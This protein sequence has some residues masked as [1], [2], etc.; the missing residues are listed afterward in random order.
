MSIA[1]SYKERS[2]AN[3]RRIEQYAK[4][5]KSLFSKGTSR[6]VDLAA[7]VDYNKK[8]GQFYFADYPELKKAVDSVVDEIAKGMWNTIYTGR[9]TEW[10]RGTTDADWILGQMMDKSGI[11]SKS[12]LPDSIGKLLNNHDAALKAFQSRQIGG[13]NLSSRVWNLANQSKIEAE[14]A[15]SI[16]NGT[17]AQD[18]A[19]SM[20]QYLKEPTKLFRRVRD[21][22]GVLRLSRAAK[23]FTP[24]NGAYRSSY[25]NALRLARNEINMAYRHAEQESYKDK[26][27]VVGIEIKRSN[28]PYDC[29]IC[30]SLAGKY[31][32]D[33]I[34]SGWH[35]NCRCYM[36]PITVSRQEFI[37]MITDEDIDPSQS[38]NAVNDVPDN[39]KDWISQNAE[40]MSLAEQRGTEP[41]FIK[42]NPEYVQSI[43][44]KGSI[45]ETDNIAKIS[46]IARKQGT[47]SAE[48]ISRVLEVSPKTLTQELY[49]V[50]DG[51]YDKGR[52]QLHQEIIRK[53]L[54]DNSSKSDTVFMLGGAPAN[55]KSTLVDSGMLKFPKGSLVID[56]D[57]VKAMIP[58]Y[59]S[60]LASGDKNLVAAAA[61]FVHEESSMLGKSIQEKAFKKGM[62]VVI[63]GVNDGKFEKVQKNVA[64]IKELT[65]GKRVRADYVTLD[66][67]LSL[68]LAR[69]RAAKTGRMVPEEVI[70]SGNKGIAEI[71]PKLIENRTFDELYLWDTNINGTPRLIL[72][73]IDGKLEIFDDKLYAEFLKKAKYSKS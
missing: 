59:A 39:F 29:D 21:E 27:Y 1:S 6:F 9:S 73:Q 70:L 16:A 32:K 15:R 14:L 61:N 12:S 53:Y 51:V 22:F 66:T 68:K 45:F 19:E 33:F 11:K 13:M 41:Y 64:R 2:A 7:G 40:R 67:D 47:L 58:E 36:V 25:R 20:M 57:K 28:T 42:D 46:E 56:A 44:K 26:D 8:E 54:G 31:P 30:G 69:A 38:Q 52:Q 72:R 55:G 49:Q 71:V 63:D 5:L 50:E 62:S 17:S 37:D 35:P 65:G 4:K 3:L 48:E 23:A 43:V 10:K 34:W 18:V 24:D 60:M